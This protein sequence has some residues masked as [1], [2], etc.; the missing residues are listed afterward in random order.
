MQGELSR[1]TVEGLHNVRTIDIPIEDNKLI[2]VGENGTGKSTV[3]NIIYFFLTAQWSRMLE[4]TFKSVS[5]VLNNEKYE[6]SRT[7]IELLARQMLRRNRALPSSIRRQIDGIL[8]K[9]S[10]EEAKLQIEELADVVGLPSR[11]LRSELLRLDDIPDLDKT[12]IEKLKSLKSSVANQI[13]YLPTYRRIEQD[14][15]RI[16][17]ELDSDN[18]RHTRRRMSRRPSGKGY[19]E[20]VEFGME[21]VEGTIQQRTTEMKEQ[22]RRDLSNLTGEYLRDVIQGAYRSLNSS[23][24]QELDSL[25][26][27]EIFGR[28]PRDILPESDKATLREIIAEINTT[29]VIDDKNR[30]VAH[31]LTKLV[32]LYNKQQEDEKNI[33]DFVKICNE[34]YLSG[35]HFVYDNVS[36]D[37]SIAQ[38]NV[39]DDI[40]QL[41]LQAL[42]SGEKQI[43]SLFSH[44][45]LSGNSS[46][47]VI[48][49]EPELSLSVP[50]QKRF[51][52]DILEK[53]NGLIAVTHSPFIFDNEL[54]TYAHSLEEYVIPF[55]F[56]KELEERPSG[57]LVDEDLPF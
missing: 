40:T 21:D 33:R 56:D 54:R 3:A 5:A 18:L 46:H 55:K 6:F 32:Q 52:P 28:I 29:G 43:V 34:G 10:V 19:I 44:L 41:A 48:I 36:F 42:S 45:Y 50:W 30:V 49:D 23:E 25:R 8:G 16:L 51:L 1:F 31:F 38:Q 12:Q 2:L 7:E 13:L 4:N 17:P 24:L 53:C 57:E 37:V 9:H 39:T 47:F 20:L 26:I 35:K 27:D 22:V 11:I 14:L 15:E